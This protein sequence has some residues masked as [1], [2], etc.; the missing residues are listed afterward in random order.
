MVRMIDYKKNPNIGVVAVANDNIAIVPQ[1]SPK[2]FVEG[3][4]DELKVEIVETNICG[5]SVV[6]ALVALNNNGLL[7]NNHI[8]ENEL[9]ILKEN[10][11]NVGIVEDRLNALGNLVLANDKGA[12]VT[13]GFRKSSIKTMEDVLNCEI[14]EMEIENYRTV[15]SLGVANNKGAVLHPMLSEDVLKE[16]E[17]VLK[18]NVDVGTVNRGVGFVKT[19][20]IANNKG[21]VVGSLT[22]GIEI[23]RLEDV[24]GFL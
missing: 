21:I 12:V 5:T 11:I 8:Y 19:G 17:D 22:T 14:V 9:K 6:G 24:L 15:G 23:T 13:K 18:V 1:N 16:I 2:E 4:R 20:A 10:D 7:V 3:I